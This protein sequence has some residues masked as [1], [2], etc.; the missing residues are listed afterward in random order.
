VSIKFICSCG[1]HLRARDEMAR[2][3]SICPRC[4][5]PVG[6]PALRPTHPGTA[7]APMTPSERVRLAARTG[8]P[9]PRAASRDR[10]GALM[11]ALLTGRRSHG[12]RAERTLEAHW[13]DY[14]TYPWH[15]W[16]VWLGPA[17]LLALLT[18]VVLLIAPRVLDQPPESGA[19]RGILAWAGAL[20]L[21]VVAGYPCNFLGGVLRSAARGE[22][23]ADGWPGHTFAAVV[24]ASAEWLIC[25]L[26]GPVVF[27]AVAAVYW[28]RC[29]DPGPVDWLILAELGALALGY[30]MLALAAVHER[31]RLRDANPLPVIDLAHRLGWRAAVVAMAGV[32]VAMGHVLLGVL[33]AENL[34]RTGWAGALLLAGCWLCGL[35]C[36][37]VLFR[38]L[39]V[40]CYR[41]QRKD[42]GAYTRASS[43]W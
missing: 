33:G 9:A 24:K 25:F 16:G 34:H 40:W 4:G 3:R 28:M 18:A 38:L 42:G 39:G 6:I 37:T 15:D 31:G 17:L 21:F 36:A 5:Q 12:R 43:S 10:T 11:L 30:Q 8:T 23:T 29:G 27:A 13:Y 7:A 32:V 41:T 1:K 14:L 35:Y 26:A 22:G 19:A 2:R 20:V